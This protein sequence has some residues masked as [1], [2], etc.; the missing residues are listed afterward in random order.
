MAAYMAPNVTFRCD[1]RGHWKGLYCQMNY[2]KFHI[3]SHLLIVDYQNR[4]RLSELN[5]NLLAKIFNEAFEFYRV[6]TLT[7]LK[8]GVTVP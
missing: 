8:V 3:L 1:I 2:F 7:N 5:L 4:F 6:C